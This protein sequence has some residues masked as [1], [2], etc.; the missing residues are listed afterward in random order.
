MGSLWRS[1]GAKANSVSLVGSQGNH[2]LKTNRKM[3]GY[4]FCGSW[5]LGEVWRKGK[6]AAQPQVHLRAQWREA[7]FLPG[8]LPQPQEP[9][10]LPAR[11][12][13]SFNGIQA[14][15]DCRAES[16]RLGHHFPVHGEA[17]GMITTGLNTCNYSKLQTMHFP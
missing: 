1:W 14:G 2:P 5:A 12:N 16:P 3:A 17:W 6:S 13:N 7:S 4:P 8:L 11:S 9:Q 15:R 10:L